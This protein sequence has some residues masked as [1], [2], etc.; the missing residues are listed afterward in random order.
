MTANS[1]TYEIP[2]SIVLLHDRLTDRHDLP[3]GDPYHPEDWSVAIIPVKRVI[4]MPRSH[5]GDGIITCY[6]CGRTLTNG[7]SRIRG[8]GP[9]CLGRYGG[10]PG[11]SSLDEMRTWLGFLSRVELLK[12]KTEFVEEQ[13]QV[14]PKKSRVK[15][16]KQLSLGLTGAQLTQLFLDFSELPGGQKLPGAEV[17]APN[18]QLS[19]GRDE[20]EIEILG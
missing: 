2:G 10:M 11:R 5:K 19:A 20:L 8:V 16:A 13:Q 17:P 9:I 18:Q 1:K 15:K 4:K 3:I 14:K 6:W 7:E 12:L